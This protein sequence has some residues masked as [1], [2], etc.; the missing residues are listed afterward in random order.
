MAHS[1]LRAALAVFESNIRENQRHGITQPL[2]FHPGRISSDHVV[3][4]LASCCEGTDP[5]VHVNFE[6]NRHS[7]PWKCRQTVSKVVLADENEMNAPSSF[8]KKAG[9]IIFDLEPERTPEQTVACESPVKRWKAKFELSQSNHSV[10]SLSIVSAPELKP[11]A[12]RKGRNAIEKEFATLSEHGALVRLNGHESSRARRSM[13]KWPPVT[14]SS[15]EDV[16]TVVS[17]SQTP[18]NSGTAVS[19][20]PVMDDSKTQKSM[21]SMQC[22]SMPRVPNCSSATDLPQSPVKKLKAKFEIS[23]SPTTIGSQP[24]ASP[25]F[26]QKASV[27]QAPRMS[28]PVTSIKLETREMAADSKRRELASQSVEEVKPRTKIE[29]PS[30]NT[31]GKPPIHVDGA[32]IESFSGCPLTKVPVVHVKHSIAPNE[33]QCPPDAGNSNVAS[34]I[35]SPC[36]APKKSGDSLKVKSKKKKQEKS[37]VLTDK[38]KKKKLVPTVTAKGATK[39]KMTNKESCAEMGSKAIVPKKKK[40]NSTPPVT[41]QKRKVTKVPSKK[42]VNRPVEA[43]HIHDESPARTDSDLQLSFCLSQTNFRFKSLPQDSSF[44]NLSLHDDED[45]DD[46]TI[47]VD[48]EFDDEYSLADASEAGSTVRFLRGVLGRSSSTDLDFVVEMKAKK[49]NAQVMAQ[50]YLDDS[51]HSSSSASENE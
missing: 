42:G 11:W 36:S 22:E 16:P 51:S 3:S 12:I 28:S 50:G 21:K 19:S 9:K 34:I 5:T 15:S 17:S 43:E 8:T 39:K 49:G 13:K 4:G 40:A 32:D 30:S 7:S 47:M 33:S 29:A 23:V 38:K 20:L 45:D 2:P 35:G 48:F 14:E 24:R 37:P 27:A 26:A 18:S 46:S 41:K 6:T 25:Q 1:K 31:C 44:S 10:A